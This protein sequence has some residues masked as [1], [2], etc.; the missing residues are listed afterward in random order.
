MARAR[1]GFYLFKK[2]REILGPTGA[3]HC[4]QNSDPRHH[5]IMTGTTSIFVLEIVSF[6]T[7]GNLVQ[8]ASRRSIL[9]IIDNW[10]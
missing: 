2:V 9:E 5:R 4:V 10:R 7:A 8:E 3:T 1:I 6:A